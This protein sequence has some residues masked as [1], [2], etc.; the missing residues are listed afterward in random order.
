[1]RLTHDV[2]LTPVELEKYR[3]LVFHNLTYGMKSVLDILSQHQLSLNPAL[4]SA[5]ALLNDPPDLYDGEPYPYVYEAALSTLWKEPAVY[6][7]I[8]R[9]SEFELLE[10]YVFIHLYTRAHTTLIC[11][12]V[13]SRTFSPR[14]HDCSRRITCRARKTF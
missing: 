1:M 6:E 8:E 4:A 9:S 2:P 12:G 5:V 3:Q 11:D 10:W 13:A 7:T 14:F